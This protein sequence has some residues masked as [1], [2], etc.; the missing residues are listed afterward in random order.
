MATPLPPR[1]HPHPPLCIPT[2][3]PQHSITTQTNAN[4]V[5]RLVVSN[6]LALVQTNTDTHGQSTYDGVMQVLY[7]CQEFRWQALM[8]PKQANPLQVRS[9]YMRNSEQVWH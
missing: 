9:V 8:Q 6:V 7:E 3:A 5:C 1:R 2:A 4:S